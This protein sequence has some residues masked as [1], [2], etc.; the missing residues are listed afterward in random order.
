MPLPLLVILILIVPQ[1]MMWHALNIRSRHARIPLIPRARGRRRAQLDRALPRAR[2]ERDEPPVVGPCAI[3]SWGVAPA[4]E[5]E[6]DECDDEGVEEERGAVV[7]RRM[8]DV[9]MG[10]D[11]K[12]GKG[13]RG[14]RT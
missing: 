5:V 4:R 6:V 10:I 12:R 7:G 9:S 1:H 8:G 2:A 14:R 3:R 13:G 11:E